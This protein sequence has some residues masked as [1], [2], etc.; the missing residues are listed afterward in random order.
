MTLG[1]AVPFAPGA[2]LTTPT[3][4]LSPGII[5]TPAQE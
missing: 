2:L 5:S 3:S 4:A 1:A